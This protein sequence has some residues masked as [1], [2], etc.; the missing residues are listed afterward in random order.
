MGFLLGGCP[1]H[2]IF[3]LDLPMEFAIAFFLNRHFLQVALRFSFP[4]IYSGQL[5]VQLAVLHLGYV[6][7]SRSQF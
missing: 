7:V 1:A 2:C 3:F 4:L 6:F 5:R